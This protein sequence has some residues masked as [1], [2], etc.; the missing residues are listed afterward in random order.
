MIFPV[1][2]E[3]TGITVNYQRFDARQFLQIPG[4]LGRYPDI[5]LKSE[6][7]ICASISGKLRG[8]SGRFS[9]RSANQT[10]RMF[11]TTI[12]SILLQQAL[13]PV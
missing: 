11:V 8:L 2:R 6:Q 4:S 7:G 12:R 13:F 1:I 10:N 5:S 3:K 9:G